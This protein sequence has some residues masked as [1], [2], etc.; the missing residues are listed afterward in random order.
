MQRLMGVPRITDSIRAH[1]SKVVCPDSLA[2][3]AGVL[4]GC[5]VVGLERNR[6]CER[7]QL[8]VWLEAVYPSQDMICIVCINAVF[9]CKQAE[10]WPGLLTC[11]GCDRLSV[12][13]CYCSVTLRTPQGTASIHGWCRRCS[14]R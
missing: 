1:Y 9:T 8:A 7:K 6:S 5:L 12:L 10:A 3:A 2:P 13:P 4:M 14:Q 11:H